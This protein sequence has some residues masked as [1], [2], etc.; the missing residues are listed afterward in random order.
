MPLGPLYNGTRHGYL[1]TKTIRAYLSGAAG[2][3]ALLRLE[4][5][6]AAAAARSPRGAAARPAGVLPVI[7]RVG[8]G[9]AAARRVHHGSVVPSC[10]REG[11][12]FKSRLQ[13]MCCAP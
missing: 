11:T 7:G 10:Q 3:R 9:R 8:L 5:L 6:P 13:G 2:V 12:G 1:W 4:A